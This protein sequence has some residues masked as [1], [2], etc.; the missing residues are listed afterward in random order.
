MFVCLLIRSRFPRAQQDRNSVVPAKPRSF[1]R[2]QTA[3][4]FAQ[5]LSK[6]RPGGTEIES[7]DWDDAGWEC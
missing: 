6:I 7:F 4:Y 2:E 5:I 1:Q 3:E